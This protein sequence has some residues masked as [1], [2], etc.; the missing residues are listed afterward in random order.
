MPYRL[1]VYFRGLP[2]ARGEL[3]NITRYLK[4]EA[5]KEVTRGAFNAA[6]EVFTENFDN[7]GRNAPIKWPA[8]RERTQRE[9][10]ALGF[11]PD[12][13]ILIRYGDLKYAVAT[14]LMDATGPTTFTATDA[15]GGTISLSLNISKTGGVAHATGEKAGNQY[16]RP[17]WYANQTVKRAVRKEAVDVLDHGIEGLS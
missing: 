2:K 8:L 11:P 3:A 5:G 6:G 4:N 1:T 10:E 16:T 12:H 14:R 9:R 17:F 13:P 15:Q 7:E